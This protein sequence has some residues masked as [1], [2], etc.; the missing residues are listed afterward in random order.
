[1]YFLN[2][3]V[4]LRPTMVLSVLRQVEEFSILDKKTPD[5]TYQ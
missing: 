3:S 5:T 4:S 2:I 1:M